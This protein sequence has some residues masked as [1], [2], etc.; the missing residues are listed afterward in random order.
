MPDSVLN[1]ADYPRGYLT[2]YSGGKLYSVL[3]TFTILVVIFVALRFYSRSIKSIKFGLDDIFVI[4]S[5]ITFLAFNGC[6]FAM[7]ERAGVGYHIVVV[8]AQSPEQVVLWSK[9]IVATPIV[10]LVAVVFPKLAILSLY[11]RIFTLRYYRNLCYIL[12]VII[13]TNCIANVIAGC[14]ECIP[15][16]FLWDKTIEGGRCFNIDVYFRWAS[17]VNIVTDCVMLVLPIPVVWK[18]QT[19]KEVRTGLVMTFTIGSAGL[20]TSCLRFIGFFITDA[21]ADGTWSSVNVLIWSECEIGVYLC[22]ACLLTFHPL[23]QI[24]AKF[25]SRVR[26]NLRSDACENTVITAA[27]THSSTIGITQ[28]FGFER[29]EGSEIEMLRYGNAHAS[30]FTVTTGGKA[31][32]HAV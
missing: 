1:P 9:F 26:N 3:Y 27:N 25:I 30:S 31:K 20:I 22:C 10:Y 6:C 12:G 15:I 17:F 29:L 24:A 16:E 2:E 5:L 11:L 13:V 19:S 21:T 4:T 8:E 32:S 14:L 18:L 28:K 23:V 7:L